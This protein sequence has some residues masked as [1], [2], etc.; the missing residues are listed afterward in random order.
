M[1]ECIDENNH[2][3]NVIVPS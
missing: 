1:R 3:H 2:G